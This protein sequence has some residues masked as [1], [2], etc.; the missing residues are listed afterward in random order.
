LLLLFLVPVVAL[1]GGPVSSLIS[2][3]TELYTQKNPAVAHNSKWNEY[4]VVCWYDRSGNDDIRA[5]RLDSSGRS[6]GGRW[7]AAGPGAD[8]RHPTVTYNPDRNEYLVVWIETDGSNTDRLKAQRLA[9]DARPIGKVVTIDT[10][11][12]TAIVPLAPAVAYASTS[13]KYLVVWERFANIPPVVFVSIYG[14]LLNNMG[15]LEGPRIDISI[16]PGGAGRHSPRVAYN[17]SR[18]GFLVVWW[19]YNPSNSSN[20]V[21][22]RLLHGTGGP[23]S[24]P[25]AIAT[26]P[27]DDSLP[28]VASIPTGPSSY[29][30]LVV[31][32]AVSSGD[33]HVHG[34]L[35]NG[36]GD[37]APSRIKIADFHPTLF[38]PRVAASEAGQRYLVIFQMYHATVE[39][40][41]LGREV[42]SHGELMGQVGE[43]GNSWAENLAVASGSAGTFLAAWQEGDK[44]GGDHDILGRFWG[45]RAYLPL[46]IR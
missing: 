32:L 41:L 28:D 4:L 11:S 14:Q 16:D 12:H 22:G 6:L 33:F 30:F 31:W 27:N 25:I 36:D 18:N 10:G 13:K 26:G 19:Q 1:A 39:K 17:R 9:A 46:V 37:P 34:K 44:A 8:R 24:G 42:S 20:D 7:V 43:F 5:D 38:V 40:P 35:V 15:E 23:S 29:K 45:N 3:N 2:V 21:Y